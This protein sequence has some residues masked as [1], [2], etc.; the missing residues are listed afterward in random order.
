[1]ANRVQL[2]FLGILVVHNSPNVNYFVGGWP[3]EFHERIAVHQQKGDIPDQ[4]I[5]RREFPAK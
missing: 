5:V 4:L 3:R 2:S 1:M